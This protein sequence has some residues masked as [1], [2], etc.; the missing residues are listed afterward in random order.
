MSVHKLQFKQIIAQPIEVVWQFFSNPNN[1]ETITPPEMGFK[2]TV[3]EDDCVYAGMI[4]LHKVKPVLNLPINW[5][6]EITQ[7]N[8]PNLFIDEQRKGNLQF[9]ASSTS[10]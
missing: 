1:L 5:M 9:L 7:V 4:I 6:T 8:A 10:F 2:H 3:Y